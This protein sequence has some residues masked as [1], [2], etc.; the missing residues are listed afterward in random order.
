MLRYTCVCLQMDVAEIDRQVMQE[1]LHVGT[2]LIPGGE[3]VNG[4][5]M[6]QVV[7]PRLLVRVSPTDARAIAQNSE[8]LFERP[9]VD[10]AARPRSRKRGPRLAVLSA[11]CRRTEPRPGSV[12]VP[13]EPVA[14]CRTSCSESSGPTRSSPRRRESGLLPRADASRP[15]STPES[16]CGSSLAPELVLRGWDSITWRRRRSSSRV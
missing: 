12:A 13:R 11:E 1:P 2:L 5:R 4:E 8:V 10:G 3:T 6:A 16:S 7:N 9:R 14:S 15:H